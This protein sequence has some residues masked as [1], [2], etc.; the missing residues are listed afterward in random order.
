MHFRNYNLKIHQQWHWIIGA[1]AFLWVILRSGINPKRMTYPCQRAAIPLALNWILAILA[2]FAGSLLFRRF[3]KFSS[4]VLLIAGTIWFLGALP[5]LTRSD[6]TEYQ[7][8]PTW[9]VS[10]PVSRVFVMDA[11]PPT[12]GSLAAGDASVPDEYLCDPAIDTLLTI[13]EAGGVILHRTASYPD[14]IVN[15]DAIVIIKGNFQWTQQNTTSSDRIKGL[16]WQILNHPDGFSGEIIV[17]DNT[18]DIGTG[19]NENDNNSEDP[20]QS[21]IDVVNTFM[22]KGHPVYV[23][24]WNSMWDDVAEEYA[25]GDYTDGYVFEDETLITYPKFRTPSGNYYVSLRNGIWDSPS[26]T[27]DPSRLC[28]IDFP[29]LKG[30]GMAGATIAVKNWIGVLTTAHA[31]ERYGGWQP[32]HYSYFFSDYALV[33]RVMAATFPA[34]TIVDATWTNT[35]CGANTLG[36][37]Q[38]TRMLVAST[39]PAAA[40]WYAARW[41]LTPIARNPGRTDP[42]LPGSDYST[43]L[44]NWTTFLADSAGFPCT[45]DSTE[46]AVFDRSILS[47]PYIWLDNYIVDDSQ[48]NDNGRPDAGETVNLIVTLANLNIHA[49]GISIVLSSDDPDVQMIGTTADFGDLG[50]DERAS[51]ESSPFSFSVSPDMIAHPSAFYL[52]ITAD[53][54][55]TKIISFELLIGTPTVLLVDDDAG[56]RYEGY[57]TEGLRAK[58]V[59]PEMWEVSTKGPPTTEELQEYEVVAW[60]TGDDR[61][62]TLTP[63]EQMTL[64]AFLDQGGR[65]VLAGQNIGYDLVENGSTDDT[66]FYTDYLHAEYISDSI[67]ETFVAGITGDPISGEFTYFSLD[68]VQTSPSVISPTE[69]ASPVLR[70]Q[71]SRQTAAIKYEGDYRLVYFALGL[72]GIGAMVGDDIEA[73]GALMQ[74]TI[75]WLNYRPVIGDVNQDGQINVLDVL[76]V[77]NIILGHVEPTPAQEWSADCNVDGTIN[78]LDVIGIVNGIL[79]IGTC[80]PTG[81]TRCTPEVMEYLRALKPNLSP[82]RFAHLMNLVREVML[83]TQPGLSQNYPNPFNPTTTIYYV[84]PS[85]GHRAKSEGKGEGSTLHALRTTLTIYNILGQEV[86]TLVDE[87]KGPGE[88]SVTWDGK[89]DSGRE[90]ASG[91]YLYRLR[92]GEFS[93]TKR[94]MLAK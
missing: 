72:E 92:A 19:V 14:G 27:Y 88:Y 86:R 11:I 57:Y 31:E 90:V 58:Q 25:D 43:I 68:A 10:D 70:Y 71:I 51:N 13:L 36:W 37:H 12:T 24:D 32:L 91:L 34:L 60:F 81:T 8:L 87:M 64:S 23:L 50:R 21:I 22:A 75:D 5:D 46:I 54:G 1:G 80:P 82:E 66:A 39:D 48:G 9:E 53:G 44:R 41:I 40:S 7:P 2:F 78:V 83:P 59:Y 73:R 77:V 33:A 85:T 65:L 52:N 79:G 62:G 42:D 35:Y 4:V 3:V 61:T 45:V 67:D 94:M 38:N 18:Q 74:K 17:C 89:D 30:H 16:I 28:L 15:S 29:V 93:S 26:E 20:D 6:I 55:Y 84:I 76:F 49:T 69:G 63:E 56:K 47:E